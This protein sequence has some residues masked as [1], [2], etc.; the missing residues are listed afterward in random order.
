M[1]EWEA[2]GGGGPTGKVAALQLQVPRDEC[3]QACSWKLP[4]SGGQKAIFTL[5]QTSETIAKGACCCVQQGTR[6][7]LRRRGLNNA[8]EAVDE[9]A[10][11]EGTL[12]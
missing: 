9:F 6:K 2:L 8:I 1:A 3:A 11:L 10:F 7:T 4:L 5:A 12:G